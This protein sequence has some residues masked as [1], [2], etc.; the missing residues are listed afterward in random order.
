LPHTV[1][2]EVAPSKTVLRDGELH[3]WLLTAGQGPRAESLL[4]LLSDEEVERA[5]RF[6]FG[7]DRER[8]VRARGMLRT[9]LGRYLGADPAGLRF[10]SND[11]GKPA[12][13]GEWEGSGVNFNLSHSHEVV[14]YAFALGR[15]VG[16]DVEHVRPELAGDDIAEHFFAAPEVEALRRTPAEARAVTFFSCWTR[17]EAYIKA[18][19]EGLSLPLDSFAV[20]VDAEAREVALDARGDA[21][22]GRRWTIVS[23]S[24]A[25]GYVAA[26][27]VEGPASKFKYWRADT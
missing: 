13:A 5:G 16:V 12:L 15:E 20:S 11:Y 6:H 25:E 21:E 7:R 2:W 23:L 26:L 8:F 24:P 9:L 1:N 19:G 22:E 27:A 10:R 3:V 17:K 14:L 18:R 4:D